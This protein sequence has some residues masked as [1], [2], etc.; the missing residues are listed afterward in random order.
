MRRQVDPVSSIG[1]APVAPALNSA[2]GPL[3]RLVRIKEVDVELI[4]GSE[5]VQGVVKD[6]KVLS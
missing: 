1:R 6:W 2:D 5:K 3:M 4:R